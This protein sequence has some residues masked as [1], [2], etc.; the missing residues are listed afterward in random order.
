MTPTTPTTSNTK[1]PPTKSK[2]PDGRRPEIRIQRI[3]AIR[4][5]LD[6]ILTVGATYSRHADSSRNSSSPSLQLLP[7]PACTRVRW[8]N[9]RMA[10]HAANPAAVLPHLH[11]RLHNSAVFLR[12]IAVQKICQLRQL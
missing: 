10:R 8:H 1:S 9:R 3:R 12:T 11:R 7:P 4:R 5:T 2:P 6:A